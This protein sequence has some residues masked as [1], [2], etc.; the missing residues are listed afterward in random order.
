MAQDEAIKR[1]QRAVRSGSTDL[2]RCVAAAQSPQP[3]PHPHPPP[4][5]AAPP[6]RRRSFHRLAGFLQLGDAL[7]AGVDPD[8]RDNRGDTP[9]IIASGGRSYDVVETLIEW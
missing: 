7:R 2:V 5:G 3:P 9:L 1:L 6:F 8:V 4:S